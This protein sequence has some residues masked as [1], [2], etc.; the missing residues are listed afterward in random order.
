MVADP[1]QLVR[2]V[3]EGEQEPEVTGHGRLRGDR[4][5]DQQR[6]VS[7]NL[8]DPAITDDHR[9]CPVLVVLHE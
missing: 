1:L 8:V 5:G 4:G 9:D 3:V 6:N 7:L 2:H